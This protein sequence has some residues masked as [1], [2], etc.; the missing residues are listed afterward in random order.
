MQFE[1]PQIRLSQIA[2]LLIGLFPYVLDAQ[3]AT[4]QIHAKY[5]STTLQVDGVLDELEWQEADT[6]DDFWQYFPYDTVKAE[7]PT[8]IKVVYN[9]NTLY[10]GIR[11]ESPGQNYVVSTLKRDFSGRENDNV[12]VLLDTYCD[13]TNAF[14]F[15]VSPYGVQR[16][17]LI[18]EGGQQRGGIS[19][20]WDVKW[21]AESKMHDGYFTSEMAIPFTS[22]KFP[23]GSTKWRIRPYRANQYM[24]ER[25]SWV[26]LPQ[27]QLLVNLAYM[28]ELIFEK[29]LGKSRTPLAVI[30][31]LN[32]FTQNDFV[33]D[34]RDNSVKVGGDAKIAIGNNLNLDVTFNPDFSNVEVDDI[35]TNLTRFEISLPERRQFFI[36]NSDLFSSF[37]SNRDA[38]PFFSRRI[39]IA[40][41]TAGNTISN[42]ILGGL[43]LSGKLNQN[44]R[45]GLLNVQTTADIKNEI[46][47]NNNSMVALQRKVFN[48]SNIGAF[49]INR[50][51]FENSEFTNSEEKYNRVVGLDYNLASQNGEW[52]GK[53]FVHKSFNPDDT[54]GNLASQAFVSYN[55]RNWLLASNFIFIDE[56]FQ[57]DL[58]FIPRKDIFKHVNLIGKYF[59]PTN[60][61]ITRHSI[62]WLG[63]LVWQP[64]LDFQKTDHTY[65]VS[66]EALLKSRSTIE[67]GFSNRFIFLTDDF[68][69]TR[70]EDGVPIPGNIGYTF[71][72]LTGEFRSNRGR[73]LVLSADATIGQFFNGN[74]FSL[75]GE[76]TYRIQP[77]AELSFAANYDQ[78]RL[79][80]PHPD[81]N[82]WLLS[83][84]IDLT[85]TKSL[86]WTTIF[87]YSNQQDNLGINSRL[88]WRF[89]PLS[90]SLIHI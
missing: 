87:Q 15:G 52:L 4:K 30:P 55:S 90:L 39:G 32:T 44:W 9:E 17:M 51:T 7:Y 19:F 86:F 28:G 60:S 10:I 38:T 53:F 67:V 18:A 16:E 27:N 47:A 88:Q 77:Y 65:R 36:D 21:Q 74:R 24:N 35:I 80:D 12:T 62:Q 46:A 42:D 57:S 61:F 70:S 84:R 69:P 8:E 33:E 3:E 83:P 78:I 25:S 59:Y 71:N 20:T 56:T 29:P 54:E 31:Y 13:G 50:Q 79:P 26:Q 89:A 66:W 14:G 76:I 49:I 6:G 1:L 11:A 63:L 48:R 72:Q 58:G 2:L 40:Q 34:Q 82:L 45:L 22:L 81:A 43:R 23:E 85:F 37:G 73:I 5:I 64:T 68:D 75:G 41:D